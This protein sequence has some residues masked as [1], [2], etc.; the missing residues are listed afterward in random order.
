MA[1]SI[2]GPPRPENVLP[3]FIA[4]AH[5]G[6][7]EPPVKL[8]IRPAFGRGSLRDTELYRYYERIGRLDL[9]FALFP[10]G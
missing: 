10:G 9:Y 3:R 2:S 8:A 4:T 5:S 6:P 1:L 7:D